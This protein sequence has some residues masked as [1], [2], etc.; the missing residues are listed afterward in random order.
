MGFEKQFHCETK[1]HNVLLLN[2]EKRKRPLM[3]IRKLLT[4]FSTVQ[5]I[6][7]INVDLFLESGFRKHLYQQNQEQNIL[8]LQMS[9]RKHLM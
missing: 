4:L 3:R 6:P 8:N 1:L 9:N 2:P 5:N 7:V